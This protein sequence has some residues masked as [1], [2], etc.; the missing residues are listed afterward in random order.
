MRP[1]P[2]GSPEPVLQGIETVRRDGCP[3][4]VKMME[5]SVR[6]L[7][8]TKDLSQVMTILATASP[9]NDCATLMS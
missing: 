1:I 6:I 7:F 8:S 3:A 2:P 4:L 5:R 9:N